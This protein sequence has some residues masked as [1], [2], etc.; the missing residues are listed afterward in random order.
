MSA[1]NSDITEHKFLLWFISCYSYNGK[2]LQVSQSSIQFSRR[3]SSYKV[4]THKSPVPSR[5]CSELLSFQMQYQ[6][7][8]S[9]PIQTLNCY[10]SLKF[11][12]PRL[13]RNSHQ[14]ATLCNVSCAK[15]KKKRSP[16]HHFHPCQLSRKS[17]LLE[18]CACSVG[19][20]KPASTFDDSLAEI[21]SPAK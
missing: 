17:Q 10:F 18:G 6:S 20:L 8:S 9:G 7:F 12:S 11:S 15:R 1:S 2:N 21:L 19:T 14:G 3:N 5:S 4:F 13:P 16:K